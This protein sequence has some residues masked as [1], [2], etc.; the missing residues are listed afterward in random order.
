MTNQN[1]TITPLSDENADELKARM[2]ML[3]RENIKV[4]SE[5][6]FAVFPPLLASRIDS[7]GCQFTLS[8]S[9]SK[10]VLAV[11]DGREVIAAV[12]RLVGRETETAMTL[13]EKQNLL[14]A[15]VALPTAMDWQLQVDDDELMGRLNAAL[16]QVLAD[17][18]ASKHG[19][20][21]EIGAAIFGQLDAFAEEFPDAGIL[22]SEGS[23]TVARFF[24]VNLDPAMYDFLRYYRAE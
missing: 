20:W 22:D 8:P 1:F 4:E 3:Q 2:H 16:A 21:G 15:T 11:M 18:K 14:A 9:I 13:S 17:T 5:G 6:G 7:E 12:G 24:A 19:T 23:Q 10:Q